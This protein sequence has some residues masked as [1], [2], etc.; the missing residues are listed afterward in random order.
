MSLK[1]LILDDDRVWKRALKKMFKDLLGENALIEAVEDPEIARDCIQQNK[2]DLVSVDLDLG[3]E[4][5]TDPKYADGRTIIREAAEQE[6]CKVIV[7]ISKLHSTEELSFLKKDD[8][9][10]LVEIKVTIHSYLEEQFP[11]R[12]LFFS[13]DPT[14]TIEENI[15]IIKNDITLNKKIEKL[16]HP[17]EKKNIFRKSGDYWE[18]QF[19]EKRSSI[20]NLKGCRYIHY[21][22]N[23][24]NKPFKTVD[25]INEIDGIAIET[26]SC[27]TK[28]YFNG[29]GDEGYEGY[30]DD[31]L[32]IQETPGSSKTGVITDKAEYFS[33]DEMSYREIQK[34]I[35]LKEKQLEASN[36]KYDSGDSS[37]K[38]RIEMLKKELIELKDFG[39][40][41][42]RRYLNIKGKDRLSTPAEKARQKISQDIRYARNEIKKSIPELSDHISRCI[43]C[44]DKHFFYKVEIKY[45]WITE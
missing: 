13:K 21:L 2:Y 34:V 4:N 1:I 16:L 27:I 28:T 6:A 30:F 42:K 18:I 22:L 39:D 11:G 15:E 12:N 24:P 45:H 37:Q 20:R 38:N 31:D 3:I 35:S 8:K 41:I 7:L 25:I 36:E 43:K 9:G 26:K 29:D 33:D 17:Q 23:N 5:V 32:T 19:A 10:G 44:V 14:I 40:E